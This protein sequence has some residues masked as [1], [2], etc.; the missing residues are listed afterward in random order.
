MQQHQEERRKIIKTL[1]LAG[2][3]LHLIGCSGSEDTQGESKSSTSSDLAEIEAELEK[4]N[5]VYLTKA[6]E[7]FA[8]LATYFNKFAQ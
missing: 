3:G 1:V 2:F 8:A 6:D 7:Q 4:S 5:V